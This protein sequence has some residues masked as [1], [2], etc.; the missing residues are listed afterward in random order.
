M[1]NVTVIGFGNVGSTLALLLLNNKHPLRLNIM[2][3]D[4]SAEGAFIDLA[5]AMPLYDQKELFINN[6]EQF[7]SAQFIY[8]TAGT[9]N[10]KNTSRLT[11]AQQ[12]KKLAKEIFN[13]R[14]FLKNPFVIVITNPVDIVSYAVYQYSGLPA[15]RVFGTGT[16]LDSVRLAY[17]LSILSGKHASDFNALV[18]GEHGSSQVPIYSLTTVKGKPILESST[19]TIRLLERAKQLTEGAAAHIR[20]TQAGTTYGVAKCAEVLLNYLLGE[21]ERVLPLSMLT[22]PFYREMLQLKEDIYIS[23]LTT[24]QK[25]EVKMANNNN[26]SPEELEAYRKSAAI[27]AGFSTE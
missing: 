10:Q 6:E 12:N 18:L 15:E 9:P 13:P 25:G 2:E 11:T 5:H 3:P 8:F 7:L 22:N 4:E 27:I 14:S 20:Q 17:Y 23:C 26:L 16:M 19:F 1:I 21:E 24:I